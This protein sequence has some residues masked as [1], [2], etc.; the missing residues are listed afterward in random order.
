M[1]N[2]PSP[3]T[4]NE[5]EVREAIELLF[6]AYRDFTAEPD[7]IL[8][9]YGFGRA[10]HR[11]IYFVGRNPGST[12]SELLNI[13]RITKQSLSRVLRQLIHQDFVDQRSDRDDRRKRLLFLTDKGIELERRLTAL[14]SQRIARAYQDA[15]AQYSNEF[16]KIL[17]GII[18]PE[19]RIRFKDLDTV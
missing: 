4:E 7:K 10:H 9:Q 14:Q 5:A 17:R 15:G 11:V 6:F 8:A 19:D 18:D 2:Q 12:V 16:C 13:L 3:I 1:G